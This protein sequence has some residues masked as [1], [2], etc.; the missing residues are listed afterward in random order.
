[1]RGI[2]TFLFVMSMVLSPI[3]IWAAPPGFSGGVNNEY[4]YEEVVFVSGEAIR[5]KGTIKVSERIKDTEKSVG[6]SFKLENKDK[7]AKLSRS[8]TVTTLLDKRDDKGQTIAQGSVSKYSES[9]TIGK[10]KYEL[11][12]FQLSKS[13]VIDNRPAADFYNGNMQG[14][15][16]YKVNKDQGEIIV[17]ISG[18]DVGYTNFWGNSETQIIDY[19]IR[20]DSDSEAKESWEGHVKAS[21]SDSTTKVLKY[22]DNE[23][24]FS[25]F[26]GGHMRITNQQMVC[27]YDYDLPKVSNGKIDDDK[28]DKGTIK[29]NKTMVPKL[30]RLIVPKFRDLGGH[31]AQSYIEKLYSLDV[32]DENGEFFSPDLP[33][34]RMEFTKGV[35]RACDIRTYIEVPKK[36]SR[37]APPRRK[38]F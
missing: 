37:K 18:H 4:E 11:E 1:M 9:I 19:S 26:N 33:M 17:D 10:D 25:S 31:W 34:N 12:D 14:R 16:Y 5:L 8:I 22:S 24:N 3:N 2:L 28:R 32:F 29:M 23:A 6:Y 20:S 38:C 35:I 27:L 36:T 13:D 7:D 15:K 30:E 21:V